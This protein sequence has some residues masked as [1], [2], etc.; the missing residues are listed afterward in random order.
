MPALI[1]T[2]PG[3]ADDERIIEIDLPFRAGLFGAYRLHR[4]SAEARKRNVATYNLKPGEWRGTPVI[5][6]AVTT[7]PNQDIGHVSMGGANGLDTLLKERPT[8]SV[9]IVTRT[10][11]TLVSS[12]RRPTFLDG[13]KP[14]ALGKG[15]A[16]Y[17]SGGWEDGDNDAS[18][19]AVSNFTVAGN[20]TLVGVSKTTTTEAVAEWAAYLV[21]VI[22]GVGVRVTDLTNLGSVG[23]VASANPRTVDL[24]HTICCGIANTTGQLGNLDL[25]Y[26]LLFDGEVTAEQASQNLPAISNDLGISLEPA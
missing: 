4:G 25:A 17:L 20:P 6:D 26:L 14:D 10:K 18:F 15:L 21:N 22:S 3:T 7:G 23:F 11:D 5:V 2:S 1:F 8:M 9:M 16:I 12:A 24:D 19:R 13:S